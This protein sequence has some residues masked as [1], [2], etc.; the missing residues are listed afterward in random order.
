LDARKFLRLCGRLV[1][2]NTRN[3]QVTIPSEIRNKLNIKEGEFLD[4]SLDEKE[5]VIIARPYRR[6]WTA[7]KLN[8]RIDQEDIDRATK[9]AIDYVSLLC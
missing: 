4:V 7:V 2:K 9:E 8:R 6:R 5:E 1:V 3:F